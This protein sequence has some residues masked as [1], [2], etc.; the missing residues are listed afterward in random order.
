MRIGITDNLGQ[1]RR[2]GQYREWIHRVDPSVEL[3]KLSYH[4][5]NAS[6]VKE[7]DALLLTGG[8]DVHP[9]YYGKPELLGQTEEVNELRDEFELSVIE[10]ALETDLPI[11]GICRGMQILNVALGG[12]LIVDLPSGGFEF[13]K[14]QDLE[15]HRHRVKKI[16]HSLL[17]AITGNQE[18][19][20]NSIHHQAVD[21]LGRGLMASGFS[22]DG[23]VEAVEWAMKDRMPFLLCVQWHP[24]RMSDLENPLSRNIAEFFLREVRIAVNP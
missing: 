23:V 16:P 11:L 15:D 18:Q 8:G 20:V 3:V 2:F 17:E 19:E 5:D 6:T 21:R 9:K 24:E 13:H 7:V 12:T 14:V 22:P 4:L 1:E 10:Q